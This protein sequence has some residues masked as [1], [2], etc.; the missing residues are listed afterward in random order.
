MAFLAP[1]IETPRPSGFNLGQSS[2]AEEGVPAVWWR[3]WRRVP[4][5]WVVYPFNQVKR[6]DYWFVN[7]V[8]VAGG[9]VPD[10]VGGFFVDDF[11]VTLS[12][13]RIAAYTDHANTILSDKTDS[14]VRI[15]WGAEDRTASRLYPFRRY[16]I[17]AGLPVIEFQRLR[18]PYQSPDRMPNYELLAGSYPKIPDEFKSAG[19]PATLLGHGVNPISAAVDLLCDEVNGA[20]WSPSRF[21]IPYTVAR[22]LELNDEAHAIAP[23]MPTRKSGEKWLEEV[24]RYFDGFVRKR[25]GL[26]QIGYI[27]PEAVDFGAA[28]DGVTIA[29]FDHHHFTRPPALK[30]E[31][32]EARPDLVVGKVTDYSSLAYKE[33]ALTVR[34]PLS[35]RR[36]GGEAKTE[37]VDASW[38]VDLDS[39]K[40]YLE[41]YAAARSAD[42]YTGTVWLRREHAVTL[43][44][45]RLARGDFFWLVDAVA[46]T[47][48]VMRVLTRSDAYASGECVLKVETARGQFPAPFASAAEVSPD[49]TLPDVPALAA[50]LVVEW[51]WWTGADTDGAVAILAARTDLG[52]ASASVWYSPDD[53]TYGDF[54]AAEL[55]SAAF[56]EL[57]SLD[58][59]VSDS[60]PVLRV[61]MEAGM[62]L[63]L[64]EARTTAEQA[65]D[66]LL[67]LLRAPAGDGAAYGTYELASVGAIAAVDA[68]TFDLTVLRGRQGTAAASHGGATEVW[69]VL[70][71]ALVLVRHPLLALPGADAYFKIQPANLYQSME[72]ATVTALA[73]T[74]VGTGQPLSNVSADIFSPY[75]H[76][77]MTW[78]NAAHPG[79]FYGIVVQESYWP[80]GGSF[81]PWYEILRTA[82]DATEFL[83]RRSLPGNYKYRLAVYRGDW[84]GAWVEPG[85]SGLAYVVDLPTGVTAPNTASATN[86]SVTWVVPA[87]I[88]IQFAEIY[89]TPNGPW[90][91]G[92]RSATVDVLQGTYAGTNGGFIN[93]VTYSAHVIFIDRYGN[94]SP[95]VSDNFTY[96]E[97]S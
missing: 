3:G 55:P 16:D 88:D 27:E 35:R 7:T 77:R 95:A 63:D 29:T 30:I 73:L 10:Q 90:G 76:I 8:A 91:G 78:D 65:A 96:S 34:A 28:E 46:G 84:Q 40:A 52:L 72:L 18:M 20:G 56:A 51:P 66:T 64:L 97:P 82:S 89:V 33:A 45:A 54:A 79:Q 9:V 14:F 1:K 94:R 24:L 13:G 75:A 81:G 53:I 25:A 74:L 22:A 93:G 67:A 61:N 38:W 69:L 12:W 15:N 47:A 4:L 83:R 32:P 48:V 59:G 23:Y 85:W 43:A 2:S 21:D 49:P 6:S 70:R 86:Y 68:D 11:F 5:R 19:M 92:A 87:N 31:S 71:S 58:A 80:E 50:E 17:P 60:A 42:Q 26:W 36:R 41:R 62:P 57:G 44:G 37:S 39:G